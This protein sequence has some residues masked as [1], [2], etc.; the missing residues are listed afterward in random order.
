MKRK[1]WIVAIL[2]ILVIFAIVVAVSLRTTAL[3]SSGSE[4]IDTGAIGT[5]TVGWVTVVISMD[6]NGKTYVS[7]VVINAPEGCTITGGVI[8]VK[9]GTETNSYSF[10]GSSTS[11]SF[12]AP[13]N[14]GGQR[15]DVSHVTV[16]YEYYCATPT[17][18]NT[19]T[20]PGGTPTPSNPGNTP[21][22]PGGTPTPSDPGNTTPTPPNTTT[23]TPTDPG[24]TPTPTPT[25]T[26][27][28]GRG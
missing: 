12:Y 21:T 5:H 13:L 19:P 23:P 6:N 3:A 24:E 10:T 17:P 8:Y 2:S 7:S 25:G 27:H 14:N 11:G 18:P 15:A 16:N 9:G 28:S 20:P 22:P 1:S 26:P 4:K